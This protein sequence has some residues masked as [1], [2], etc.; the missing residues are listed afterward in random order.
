MPYYESRFISK[1]LVLD[2]SLARQSSLPILFQAANRF[3]I[4]FEITAAPYHDSNEI[5][6]GR[7]L[8][9]RVPDKNETLSLLLMAT[10]TTVL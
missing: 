7:E 3:R 8:P 2:P 9:P 10:Y 5:A 6:L 1:P 4:T